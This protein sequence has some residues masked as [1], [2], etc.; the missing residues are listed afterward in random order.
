MAAKILTTE[1]QR[2]PVWMRA[3]DRYGIAVVGWVAVAI[4]VWSWGGKW[5]DVML[6]GR[7]QEQAE[8]SKFLQAQIESTMAQT[9]AVEK[10]VQREDA[11]LV[12]Q[13]NVLKKHDHQTSVLESIDMNTGD[14]NERMRSAEE[15]MAGVP[16][17]RDEMVSLLQQISE[18][19]KAQDDG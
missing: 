16:A 4:A 3:L 1:P 17:Q 13:E 9:R 5:V 18:S 2:D 14:T 19:L 11:T 15:A 8:T 12:F 6:D 7:R 10:L